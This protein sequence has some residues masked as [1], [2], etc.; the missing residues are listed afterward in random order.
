MVLD[1]FFNSIFG[2]S[3]N[4]DPLFGLFIIALILTLLIT[5]V[6]KL[7]TDQNMMK[8]LKEELKGIRKE[9]KGSSQDPDRIKELNKLSMEKSLKQMKHSMKPTIIT[10]LPLLL[11]YAWIR[12]VYKDISV[13]FLG[14]HSP[15]WIYIIMSIVLSFVLR[16][17][18]KVH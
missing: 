6:Y 1:S 2:W 7:M 15:I 4:I 16:K 12:N 3:I 18:L 8:E 14:I 5:I 17:I 10:M 11:A 9:M 13:S